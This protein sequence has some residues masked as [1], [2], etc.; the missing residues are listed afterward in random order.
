MSTQSTTPTLG[1]A[2]LAAVQAELREHGVAVVP[3]V[4]DAAGAT[5]ALDRLWAASGASEERGIPAHIPGL[6]PNASN[7]RVFN[8]IDL[9]PL[10][11]ELIAHPVADAIIGGLLGPDYIVSNFTANI[12]RPGSASMVV[13]SD[14]AAVAPEPWVAPQ[15]ANVIW[16]L[17][18]VHADNGATLHIP[19]SHHYTTAADVPADP[20]AHMVPFEATAGSIIVMEGR[21]WHTSGSNVTD[22]ED[23]ALLFGYYSKPFLRPQWNFTASLSPERRAAMG[24]ALRYRLGLDVTL[25]M[26]FNDVFGADARP[27]APVT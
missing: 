5:H 6:D 24:P 9:D 16:C 2:A 25:N 27:V 18:D 19:G 20:M 10:F 17:T 22:D 12:A 23:R 13:H 4:L 26:T 3:D 1:P 14:L 11:G 8:L 15:T 21:V 7:V